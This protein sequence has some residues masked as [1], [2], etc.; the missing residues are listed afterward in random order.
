MATR[1]LILQMMPLMAGMFS[2]LAEENVR[3]QRAALEL[4]YDYVIIGEST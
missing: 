1:G 2:R 4:R 3:F